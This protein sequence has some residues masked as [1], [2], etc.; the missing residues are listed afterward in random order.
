MRPGNH[1]LMMSW[2]VISFGTTG[3]F[4]G[5]VRGKKNRPLEPNR[6]MDRDRD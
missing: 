5:E 2:E 1:I 6:D 3:R 4:P